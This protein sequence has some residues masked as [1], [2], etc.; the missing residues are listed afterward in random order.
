MCSSNC[1]F[2][3]LSNAENESILFHISVSVTSAVYGPD[4]FLC[5]QT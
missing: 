2:S 3:F 5:S 4:Q 1:A